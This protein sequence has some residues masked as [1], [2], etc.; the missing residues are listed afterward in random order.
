MI[1]EVDSYRFSKFAG[2]AGTK[3]TATLTKD[4]ILEAFDLAAVTMNNAEVPDD[5]SRLLF[6][7]Q[8]LEL[9][10]RK[11]L[12]RGGFTNE[13]AINTRIMSYNGMNLV[14]VP[15]N[16]FNT[17]ITLNDGT[18]DVWGYTPGGDSINFLLIDP[19]AVWVVTRAASGKFIT[20]AENQK[21]DSNEFMFRICH[22]AG[23]I[24][25]REIGIYA[26]TEA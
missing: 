15:S 5:G 20:A 23:A 25:T 3:I 26:N 17:A 11:A 7:N 8:A 21:R 13:G 4:N 19:K 2:A 18:G 10:V 6:V 9:E 22:D 12:V 16:R 1:P 14:F 24:N